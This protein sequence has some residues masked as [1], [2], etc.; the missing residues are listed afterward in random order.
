MKKSSSKG[1]GGGG[2]GEDNGSFDSSRK[3]P[4]HQAMKSFPFFISEYLKATCHLTIFMHRMCTA[5]KIER[6]NY[7]DSQCGA[8]LGKTSLVYVI[9][10][11]NR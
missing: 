10:P 6:N 2:V 1:G 7:Q 9:A 5:G 3:A 11:I 4:S 8:F